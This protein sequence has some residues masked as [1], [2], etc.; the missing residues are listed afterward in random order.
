MERGLLWL[1]LLALFIWLAWAGWH[2]YQKLEAYKVWAADFDRAKYDIYAA[3]G[4]RGMVLTWGRPTRQGPQGEQH[5]DLSTVTTID[6]YSGDRPLP[7]D[8]VV[9]K[10]CRTC[11]RLTQADG[12]A[13]DIPFTDGE[14]TQ[15][16][17]DR[18]QADLSPAATP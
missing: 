15:R 6:I 17:G 12:R 1:P 9:P 4:Q 18:L 10:G 5:L 7:Q 14:L 13:W 2:E 3:L 16:W 8:A 11:L